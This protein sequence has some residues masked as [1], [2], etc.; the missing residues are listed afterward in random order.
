VPS[1]ECFG[2]SRPNF[3]LDDAISLYRMAYSEK[4]LRK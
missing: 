2:L 3:I 1:S 4:V